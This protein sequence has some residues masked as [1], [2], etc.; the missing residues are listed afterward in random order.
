MINWIVRIS[1]RK[2]HWL[3][4][5]ARAI[6]TLSAGQDGG[7]AFTSLVN[8]VEQAGQSLRRNDRTHLRAGLAGCPNLDGLH[9]VG[10]GFREGCASVLANDD[11]PLSVDAAFC[12]VEGPTVHGRFHGVL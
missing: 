7:A 10:E 6:D 8:L 1:I 12:I 11:D 9:S 2:H 3:Q 5:E 4:E